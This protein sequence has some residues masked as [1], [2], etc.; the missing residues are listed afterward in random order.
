MIPVI[1]L[2]TPHLTLKPLG[3]SDVEYLIGVH[4]ASPRTTFDDVD[5]FDNDADFSTYILSALAGNATGWTIEHTETTVKLGTLYLVDILMGITANFHPVSD[6]MALKDLN[7]VDAQGRRLRSMDEA[8][9][10]AFPWCATMWKLQRIGGA[11]GSHNVPALKLCERLGMR[12][13]GVVRQGMKVN[14]QPIDLI[15]YGFTAQE[16]AAWTVPVS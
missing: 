16:L 5:R 3:A 15:I 12:R 4:R 6:V 11:F 14:E 13:E 10:T 9:Q 1:E 2:R 8:I 7:P